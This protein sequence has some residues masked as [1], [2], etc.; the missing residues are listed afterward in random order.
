VTDDP[1]RHHPA[2]R[3]RIAAPETSF[4][5]GFRPADFDARFSPTGRAEDWRFSDA[6]IDAS[7]RAFLAGVW[8]RDLWVFAYG[9]L[10]WDPGFRFAEVR[11][12]RVAG[13]ARRF[14]LYDDKGGRGSPEAP[15]LMA[16]LDHVTS[17]EALA[18]EGLV[19][20]IAADGFD[21]ETEILWRRE[22]IAH[23]YRPIMIPALTA[24]GPVT[25][26]TFVADHSAP[27][28]RT[29]LSLAEQARLLA[30]GRGVLGTSLHYIETLA[31]QLEALG[32]VDADV[33][34]LLAVTRT[35]AVKCEAAATEP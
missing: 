5:R 16:A 4:W 12:G 19:F 1:F 17:G 21:A 20:R 33:A 29:D 23:A 9:S 2:L 3:E 7:R 31:G 11:R 26:L 14:C 27:M 22:M 34:G 13:F 35:H 18:C 15:G 24:Q 30:T 10:M 6:Q 28:I 8:G 32:I 25:A